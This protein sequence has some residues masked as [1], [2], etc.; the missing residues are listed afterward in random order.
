[1]DEEEQHREFLLAALRAASLRMKTYDAD[2]TTIGI[3]LRGDLISV[4]TAVRWICDANLQWAVGAIP[5]DVGR[6]AKVEKAAE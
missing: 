2:L 3:A 4:D 5:E 1:M 6:I